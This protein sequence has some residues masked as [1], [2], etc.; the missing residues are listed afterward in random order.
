MRSLKIS[1]MSDVGII[2]KNGEGV[3]KKGGMPDFFNY[4]EYKADIAIL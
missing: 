1:K 2:Y 3:G 4:Y